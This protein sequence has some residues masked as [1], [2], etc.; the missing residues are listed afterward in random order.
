[1]IGTCKSID[2]QSTL[3]QNQN[4]TKFLQIRTVHKCTL[5]FLSCAKFTVTLTLIITVTVVT[6]TITVT[7]EPLSMSSFSLFVVKDLILK[8]RIFSRCAITSLGHDNSRNLIVSQRTLA[9]YQPYTPDKPD[10]LKKRTPGSPLVTT[11]RP[12]FGWLNAVFNR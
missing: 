12:M 9:S 3:C 6:V 1:M 5:C 8:S 2:I 4:K 11:V 10:N 7:L